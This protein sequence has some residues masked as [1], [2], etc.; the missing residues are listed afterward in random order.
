MGITVKSRES[1]HPTVDNDGRFIGG[2]RDYYG[3]LRVIESEVDFTGK[4]VLDLGCSGGFFAFAI[5]NKAASVTAVDGD[6]HM[7]EKNREAAKK[8]CCTKVEF[9]CERIT[10]EFLDSLPKYDVVLF[11]SVFHHMVANS[12]VY[13][14]SDACEQDDA[15]RVLKAIRKLADVLIFEMGRPDE[16]FHWSD[17]V[18]VAVGEPRVWVPEHVFGPTYKSVKVL[19]GAGYQKWPF[20][21]LPQLRELGFGSRFGRKLNRMIGIDQRDF[22]EIYIGRS[23]R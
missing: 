5:A 3:R 6:Q 23:E 16:H 18:N 4:R 21:W 8:V 22:R 7:I 19:D 17:A 2:E 13:D 14:W 10:P 15:Q 12:A 11:L 9:I 1:Y 20:R